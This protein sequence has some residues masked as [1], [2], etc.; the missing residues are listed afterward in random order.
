MGKD[1]E[2]LRA[3]PLDRRLRHRLGLQGALRQEIDAELRALRLQ[4]VG[5]HALRTQTRDANS[6]VAVHD[7]E[8]LE[9]GE[10]GRLG[11]TV[12]C[13]EKMVQQ[14]GGG[15]GPDEI[16]V[17]ACEHAGQHVPRDVD[18]GHHV[19]L[20]DVLP[21]RVGRLWAATDP[22]ARV[23]AEDVDRPM[24]PLCRIDQPLDVGLTRDVACDRDGADLSRDRRRAVA[25]DV[26]D[27]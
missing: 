13:G 12:G 2:L 25:V 4:H 19:D 8:P 15:H 10:G 22:D 6:V 14:P 9:E 16:A 24:R 26:S 1:Q 11:D 17:L 3:Y 21:G 20:P 5:L 27:Q 23:G 7:R 18:V